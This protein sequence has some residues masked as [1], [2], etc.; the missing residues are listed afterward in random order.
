MNRRTTLFIL[1]AVLL[2]A[3]PV[4]AYQET[5][6]HFGAPF[7]DAKKVKLAD[8]LANV[9]KYADKT[10][11]IEGEVKDVCQTKGCWLVVTDGTRE[12]RVSFKGYS[13][14]VPK[15]SAGKKVT[16]EGVIQKKTISEDHA[17]HI[18]EESKDK[19]DPDTIK[20]PQQTITFEATGVRIKD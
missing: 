19:T 17:R 6:G 1:A 18:A 20:G 8:A 13:F 4:F 12:M 11:K 14:F 2:A 7:T 15:D 5:T 16:L 9:E 3:A 10:V